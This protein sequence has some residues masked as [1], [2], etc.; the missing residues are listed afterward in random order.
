MPL[1]CATLTGAMADPR[2]DDWIETAVRIAY[3]LGLNGMRVRWQLMR[4]RKRWRTTERDAEQF[5]EHVQ[6]EHKVCPECGRVVDRDAE[7]CSNCGARLPSR[8]W[9]VLERIGVSVPSMVS[10][11]SLLGAAMLIVYAMMMRAAP[12]G[13]GWLDMPVDVLVRFGAHYP[14]AIQAGELWRWGSA[15]F[16]HI[17]LWHLGFNLFALAQIGPAIEST[18]GRARMLFLF[19][20]TG[21]LANIGSGLIGMPGI[22]AGASGAIMGLIGLAAGWGQRDGTTIGHQMRNRMLKWA[23]YTMVFGFFI[24]A[25]NAAHGVGFGVGAVLGYALPTARRRSSSFGVFDVLMGAVGAAAAVASVYFALVPPASAHDWAAEWK[26][27][28]AVADDESAWTTEDQGEWNVALRDAC[29]DFHNGD[30]SSA[31]AKI[32]EA[33]D[34]RGLIAPDAGLLAQTWC[35]HYENMRTNCAR[36]RAGEMDWQR[37]PEAPVTKMLEKE[38]SMLCSGVE[39]ERTKPSPLDG[40]DALDSEAN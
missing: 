3:A 21:I 40:V 32:R 31:D 30:E 22:A 10:M 39:P 28:D 9:Q 19:M 35:A 34:R 37:V 15:I 14:P 6:Y 4:W 26:S 13:E 38:W 17:G 7:V 20:L 8:S 25:D 5:V 18:F 12:A 1:P 2:D 24:G 11:S 23:L 29:R 36:Y 33:M 27:E 16:L